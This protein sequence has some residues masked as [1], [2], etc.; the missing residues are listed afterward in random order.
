MIIKAA[1]LKRLKKIFGSHGYLLK[2]GFLGRQIFWDKE[3]EEA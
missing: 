2:D 1:W 3:K